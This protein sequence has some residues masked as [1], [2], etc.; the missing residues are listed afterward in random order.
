MNNSRTKNSFKNIINNNIYQLLSIILNF[1]VR[2][3]FI[4]TLGEKFLGLNGIFTNIL[5]IL[6]LAELGIG[7]SMVYSMYK[8]IAKNDKN[9]LKELVS[10]YKILYRKIAIIIFLFGLSFIPLLKY[11]INI[12]INMSNI[13]MYYLLYLLNSVSSYLLLYKTSI[14]I[15]DQ[16]EYIIK[17]YDT[18]FLILKSLL[19]CFVLLKYNNYI[20]YLII[21]LASTILVNVFK[22][23]KSEKEYEY[24]KEKRI[25]PKED[26]KE[27]WQ[28][29]K[30]LLFYQIGNIMLNN[31]DNILISIILGTIYVGYY[32]N[33][34]MIISAV[35][36]LCSLIF[37]S[38]QSSIGN[39]NI[40]SNSKDKLTLYKT[41]N[42]LAFFVYGFCSVMFLALF[43]DFIKFWIGSRYLLENNVLIIIIL[44]FYVCG[45]LYPNWC[46]RFTT[47]LFNMAKYAIIICSII[48]IL[49]SIILGIKFGMVGI[50]F[51]TI[52]SRL[53]TTFWY[54]PYILYKKIF[55][56][57]IRKY[58]KSQLFYFI[59]LILSF[60]ITSYLSTIIIINNP[61]LQML[62]K[63]L[64][65]GFIYIVICIII[66]GK[67]EEFSFLTKKINY[68]V[69]EV[70]KNER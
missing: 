55:K 68:L 24:I 62:L 70:I 12:D 13:I 1:V 58:F 19:Q 51:A 17:K 32:S 69:K 28:N 57:K 34:Y 39:Y 10:Y 47:N 41:L 11:V 35:A 7:T 40:K 50:L 43:Q 9:K 33:Y 44:N 8:P 31:T 4:K 6:S 64:C 60:F 61:I 5:S 42:F 53:F 29:I 14:V 25:L 52:I 59:I 45:I 20:L 65:S 49:L 48:N 37:T 21:Q 3:I 46:F 22:S 2:T 27:I 56:E 66:F 54:E 18:I 36:V 38:L 15:A 30:S 23:K 26:R 16:K 67:T 63:A